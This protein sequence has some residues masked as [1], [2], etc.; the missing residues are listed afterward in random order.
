M[1]NSKWWDISYNPVTG[2]TPVS[3]GCEKCYAK[4]LA[5]RFPRIHGEGYFYDVQYHSDRLNIPFHWRK[6]K[7]IFVCSMGDLFHPDVSFKFIDR[8]FSIAF[9]CPQHT[10]MILTKRADR[11]MEYIISRPIDTMKKEQRIITT[12][13]GDMT[14]SVQWPLPNLWL[15]VTIEN[16]DNDWRIPILLQTPAAKRFVSVE[17]MLGW[18]NLFQVPILNGFGYGF[19]NSITGIPPVFNDICENIPHL[20]QVICGPETGPGARPMNL[21]WARSLR[22]QCVAAG[23]PFFYKRGELDGQLWHQFPKGRL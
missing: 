23:V 20:D 21:D 18:V 7:R 5:G 11:M 6:P 9:L 4:R 12:E 19:V 1:K 2:C 17:P 10:F 15:G 8:V 22:D 13:I 3:I 14:Y 16:Q